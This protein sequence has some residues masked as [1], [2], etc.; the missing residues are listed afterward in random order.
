MIR[1]PPRRNSGVVGGNFLAK[2]QLKHQNGKIVTAA[3]IVI[4]ATLNLASHTFVV[5]DADEAT[6]KYM[7]ERTTQFPH[8]DYQ[9]VIKLFEKYAK[10]TLLEAKVRSAVRELLDGA[11][12][13]G[14]E[15]LEAILRCVIPNEIKD[16]PVKQCTVTLWRHYA[17]GGKLAVS[18]LPRFIQA[19]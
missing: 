19:A 12:E 17:R 2:M 9:K 3:D 10:S 15:N 13:I 14:P 8:S 7:E 5:L 4:G 1:E 11:D 16:V 6:L 18:E